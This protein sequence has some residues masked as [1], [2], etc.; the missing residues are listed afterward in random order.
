MVLVVDDE[1]DVRT[2]IA[3]ALADDGHH[4][5]Q[6]GNAEDG[7]KTLEQGAYDVAFV[8]INLP[9]MSG[10]ELLER[11]TKGD[12]ETAIIIVTGRATV[13]NAIEATRRGAYDYVTK[14]FDLDDLRSLTKRVVERQALYA[15]VRT[16]RE[17][18]RAEFAPG[19]EIIGQ[20]PAMNEIYKVIGR[21]ASSPATVLIQGE[22][23]TGKEIIARAIHAFSD[24]WEAPFVAVNC[25]A[26]P[27]D[28][29][30]SEMFG[31]ERGAFTGA[32]DRRMGKF[33][34]A[35]GGTL[36]LDEISDM[37]LPL[38]AKLLRVLQEREF[39]RVGGHET[40]PTDC[41]VVAATNKAIEREVE[42]KRFRADLYFRL[43]VV[44]IEIPPLHER[45]RDIPL[46]VEF[47]IERM[48]KNHGFKVKG[49]SPDAMSLLAAH[50]WPG[51]VRELENV[52]I[53]AAAL[54]PNRLL[55]GEDIP[56]GNR[57]GAHAINDS[58]SLG[59]VVGVKIREHL[60]NLGDIDA[61][62]LHDQVV[63]LVEKPLLEAVLARTD[64]NQVRA[65][66]MLGINRNTL[67]KRITELAIELP[68]T[69]G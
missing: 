34:Q 37:P 69:R 7:L 40:L 58:M 67:R 2:I 48:N 22:S 57:P 66:E 19:I 38:Q 49:V 42:A 4:V 5:D 17:R 25:S 16:L 8:D 11:Y 62:D 39:S 31:H 61:H 43:K 21:V 13:A 63:G 51:N 59:D 26:I 47:F 28:L 32:T 29:L 56:L 23:G 36:L 46:L 3:D 30:E 6:V 24:R 14:P 1:P 68:K 55:T 53:R 18:T 50:T 45:R 54:A 41:R 35:A 33:E 65:A 64:G 10:F 60:D 52:L 12:G 27:A 15:S 20:S 9:G 44:V